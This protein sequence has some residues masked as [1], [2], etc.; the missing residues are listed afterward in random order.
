[1]EAAVLRAA[2]GGRGVHWSARPEPSLSLTPLNVCYKKFSRQ[3]DVL[4]SVSPWCSSTS[5]LYL[6]RL[7]H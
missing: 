4:T 1:V 3:A 7:G 6:S 5:L 2:P